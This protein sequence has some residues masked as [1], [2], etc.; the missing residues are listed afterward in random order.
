[1]ESASSGST[2]GGL[3]DGFEPDL[4][5]RRETVSEREEAPPSPL[6]FLALELREP[7]PVEAIAVEG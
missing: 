6:L 7:L 3:E 2:D 1:V 4:G 5:L